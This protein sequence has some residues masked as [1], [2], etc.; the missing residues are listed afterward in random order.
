MRRSIGTVLLCSLVLVSSG[1]CGDLPA[2]DFPLTE[3]KLVRGVWPA[4]ESLAVH[5][6]TGRGSPFG[7]WLSIE[8]AREAYLFLDDPPDN[9][10]SH[11]R[12]HLVLVPAGE[13]VLKGQLLVP[14]DGPGQF[15]LAEFEGDLRRPS[16]PEAA[17]RLLLARGAHYAALAAG[18]LPGAAWFRHRQ[19]STNKA[20]LRGGPLT[21]PEQGRAQIN[22]RAS[23][24]EDTYEL[25]TG[26]RAL[27]ENLQLDRLLQP[28]QQGDLT[29]EV[30]SLKGIDVAPIDWGPLVKDLKPKLDPA[31]AVIPGDQHAVFFPSFQALDDVAGSLQRG[32]LPTL[33]LLAPEGA[34]SSWKTRYERQLGLEMSELG[35]LLGPLAISAVAVTGSDP[36]FELGTDVA[37][38]FEARSAD[39]LRAF[40][41]T[42]HFAIR[43]ST[44][45]VEAVKGEEEGIPFTGLLKADR[46]VSSYLAQV[47]QLVIVTSSRAQLGRIAQAAAGKIPALAAADEYRYFRDRYPAGSPGESAFGILTDATIRRWCG[48]LWRIADSRRIRTA[49]A[50]CELAA[51]K[52]EVDLEGGATSTGVDASDLGFP[53]SGALAVDAA[54]PRSSLHGSLAFLTPIIELDVSRVSEAEAE[55]YRLFRESYQARWRGVFDPIAFQIHVAPQET[56]L[57]LTVMPLIAGTDYRELLRL[58]QGGALLPRHGDRHPEAVAHLALAIDP[59]APA[60]LEAGRSLAGMAPNLPGG[61][62]ANPLAW[63]G[64][65]VSLFVEDDPVW[66]ELA[67]QTPGRG[68]Q[69]LEA[70]LPGL[71]IGLRIEVGDPLGATAFLAAARVFLEQVAPGQLN[72][73]IRKHG[74]ASYTRIA[75]SEAARESIGALGSLALHYAFVDRGLLLT[76][77]EPLLERALERHA[78][79]AG[80]G[81]GKLAPEKPQTKAAAPAWLGRNVAL[82]LRGPFLLPLEAFVSDSLEEERQQQSWANLPILNEW[83]RYFPSEDPVAVHER[84]WG[85]KITCPA[86]GTYRWN[87]TARTMESSACGHPFGPLGAGRPA[88]RF[89]PEI[90]QLRLG[91]DF[92]ANGLR[93]HASL[94]Q[95]SAAQR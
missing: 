60:I 57:D 48:P 85:Q 34:E 54:G 87:A 19:N 25:F 70:R 77:S 52:L 69:A 31:A 51:R 5:A 79:T 53:G 43:G 75:P 61:L 65:A 14:A 8:G 82:E 78:S 92:E 16:T 42:R 6:R 15:H 37:V 9:S 38:I 21:L 30:G 66:N 90:G 47:G 20:L 11:D 88:R 81:D 46:T 86:G 55:A 91:L 72:W 67:K 33:R 63:L 68:W 28:R 26:G 4:A 22:A 83:K 73:E 56:K 35:R 41:R 29:V 49:A 7:Y 80:E 23:R 18:N 27:A 17:R 12:F 45:G 2:V 13:A 10:L 89:G 59:K 84:L 93:V 32:V 40:F 3:L 58:T 64:G 74:E 62:R 1:Q 94:E 71:P 50:L 39:S 95:K 44:P 76:L 24:L 36:F